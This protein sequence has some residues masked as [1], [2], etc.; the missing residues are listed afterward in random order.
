M[1]NIMGPP[2]YMRSVVDGNVVMR[3]IPELATSAS[4]WEYLSFPEQLQLNE[5]TVSL[6][7][8]VRSIIHTSIQIVSHMAAMSLNKLKLEKGRGSKVP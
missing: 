7:Q 6:N 4:E 1:V 2:L 8:F 5:K 3:C